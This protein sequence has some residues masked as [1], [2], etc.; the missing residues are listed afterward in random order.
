MDPQLVAAILIIIL[1]PVGFWVAKTGGRPLIGIPVLL[2]FV[3]SSIY[4]LVSSWHLFL[5][6]IGGG[7]LI[8]FGTAGFD[9]ALKARKASKGIPYLMLFIGFIAVGGG[10]YILILSIIRCL[11]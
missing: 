3:A 4:L 1:Y 10:I 7:I 11:E 2:L 5:M 9:T 6:I 8:L